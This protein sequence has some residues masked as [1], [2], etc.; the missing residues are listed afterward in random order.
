MK[1]TQR[2]LKRGRCKITHTDPTAIALDAL[3]CARKRGTLRWERQLEGPRS[4][5]SAEVL[6]RR[7]ARESS[8]KSLFKFY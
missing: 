6:L 3:L 2:G 4:F 1:P 5:Q 8:K 7:N